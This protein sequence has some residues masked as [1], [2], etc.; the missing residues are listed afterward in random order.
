[1]L[2]WL[3]R[4]PLNVAHAS[5]KKM[6]VSD[7]ETHWLPVL[8][9]TCNISVLLPVYRNELLY[10]PNL[11]P[12]LKA[13]LPCELRILTPHS[14]QPI[15]TTIF[16]AF[17]LSVNIVHSFFLVITKHFHVLIFSSIH[18]FHPKFFHYSLYCSS[19]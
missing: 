2:L 19:T 6:Q 1:M 15:S 14:Q 17:F 9:T 3:F 7:Q 13:L 16:C 4:F 8:H 11:S 12:V 18:S 5:S 10:G